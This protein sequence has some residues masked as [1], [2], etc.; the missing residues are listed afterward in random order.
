MMIIQVNSGEE[1]LG[2][3]TVPGT[4]SCIVDLGEQTSFTSTPIYQA[5]AAEQRGPK[6][7]P[8]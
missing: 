1:S 6:E 3:Q 5:Y 7:D 2:H 8:S 4:E